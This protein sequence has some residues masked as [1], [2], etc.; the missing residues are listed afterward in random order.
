MATLEKRRAHWRAN[1][2]ILA[3]LLFIWAFISFGCGIFFADY[4][5]QF[6]IGGFKLGFWMAQQGSIYVFVLLIA[7]YVVWM[8]RLDRKYDVH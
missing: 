8:N 2:R 1:L 7:V 5:D 3:L 6:K 4:L